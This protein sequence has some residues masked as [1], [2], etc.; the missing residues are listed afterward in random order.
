MD[1]GNISNKKILGEITIRTLIWFIALALITTIPL[2]SCGKPPKKDTLPSK[3]LVIFAGS[4]DDKSY[5]STIWMGCQKIIEEYGVTMDVV[6]PKTQEEA[7]TELSN[8]LS[9][10][11]ELVLIAPRSCT[12]K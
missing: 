11:V 12:T 2:L 8:G 9:R 4:K 6:E 5:N 1:L 10:G 3:I 7:E